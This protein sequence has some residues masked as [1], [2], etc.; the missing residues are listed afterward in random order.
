MKIAVVIALLSAA[1][2]QVSTMVGK[3]LGVQQT[4]ANVGAQAYQAE[5]R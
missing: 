5:A 3:G 1:C 2:Y 4:T